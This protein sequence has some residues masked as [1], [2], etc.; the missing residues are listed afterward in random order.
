[1]NVS[2]IKPVILPC[3]SELAKEG[4][5]GNCDEAT[6]KSPFYTK[7]ARENQTSIAIKHGKAP[8]N[9]PRI[10][11]LYIPF[12]NGNARGTLFNKVLHCRNTTMI[13]LAIYYLHKKHGFLNPDD[14]TYSDSKEDLTKYISKNLQNESDFLYEIEVKPTRRWLPWRNGGTRKR[15]NCKTRKR[16]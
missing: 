14:F 1:M 16:N 5:M 8:K 13:S 3:A 6:S 11:D 4:K 7:M 2:K 15:K 9:D 12:Y 10:F